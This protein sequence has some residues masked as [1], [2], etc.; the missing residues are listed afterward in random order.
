MI[1]LIGQHNLISIELYLNNCIK[2]KEKRER[3]M[4]QLKAINKKEAIYIGHDGVK[5]VRVLIGRQLAY[6]RCCPT[7]TF[8]VS[9]GVAMCICDILNKKTEKRIKISNVYTNLSQMPYFSK[10]PSSVSGDFI[11][12]KKYN[13]YQEE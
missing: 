12:N 6:S 5:E 4:A 9:R 3:I 1:N 2:R 8:D 7:D 10:F 11:L 13:K